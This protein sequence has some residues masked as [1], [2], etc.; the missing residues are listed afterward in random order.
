VGSWSFCRALRLL[1]GRFSGVRK[2]CTSFSSTPRRSL[3][4]TSKAFRSFVATIGLCDESED[5]IGGQ[6]DDAEH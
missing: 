4:G 3:V 1:S 6:R 5:L 2:G